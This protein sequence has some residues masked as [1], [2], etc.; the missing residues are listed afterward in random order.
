[1]NPSN[2]G[3]PKRAPT[4]EEG[5]TNNGIPQDGGEERN[6]NKEKPR[7][8]LDATNRHAVTNRA[9]RQVLIHQ[10][11]VRFP[12]AGNLMESLESAG[13]I[14]DA[15][16]TISAPEELPSDVVVNATLRNRLE[17]NQSSATVILELDTEERRNRILRK[18]KKR[19]ADTTIPHD[20]RYKYYLTPKPLRIHTR[21]LSYSDEEIK[22]KANMKAKKRKADEITE[23]YKQLSKGA[24]KGKKEPKRKYYGTPKA[25]T[26]K[27]AREEPENAGPANATSTPLPSISEIDSD[28]PID[29]LAKLVHKI[30]G[31]RIDAPSL[32]ERTLDTSKMDMAMTVQVENDLHK[33]ENTPP[34]EN[35]DTTELDREECLKREIELARGIEM[36]R[37]WA[38]N[39]SEDE[40]LRSTMRE[41]PG[42]SDLRNRNKDL[43]DTMRRKSGPAD[44]RNAR[45]NRDQDLRD[46]M[47]PRRRPSSVPPDLRKPREARNTVEATDYLEQSIIERTRLLGTSIE[48]RQEDIKRMQATVAGRVENVVKEYDSNVTSD[49]GDPNEEGEVEPSEDEMMNIRYSESDSSTRAP[50]PGTSGTRETSPPAAPVKNKAK[51]TKEKKKLIS[52]IKFPNNTPVKNSE[53][54]PLSMLT[55]RRIRPPARLNLQTRLEEAPASTV[56]KLDTGRGPIRSRVGCE[57]PPH[58]NDNEPRISPWL[59]W[60]PENTPR[61]NPWLLAST[62]QMMCGTAH[63]NRSFIEGKSTSRNE[64][65][66]TDQG[67]NDKDQEI[68]EPTVNED[69]VTPEEAGD[70]F[71]D[72]KKEKEKR[73]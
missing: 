62:S 19:Y 27:K 14:T 45:L 44:L 43:R 4:D 26:S 69:D 13:F 28:T 58:Q 70:E 33:N 17:N 11:P 5:E 10:V 65:S 31:P 12:V 51:E 22:A 18:A 32:Q 66:M 25:G 24:E 50:K 42:P 20:E 36:F 35:Q 38:H 7:F 47:G 15:L 30:S 60:L 53:D 9:S 55:P 6:N 57:F 72:P 48:E 1:M 59:P 67:Q 61:N 23:K 41:R 56:P 16:V 71:S 39:C 54:V 52:P 29:T 73:N 8:L 63:R 68:E 40:D 34:R 3:D 64:S 37:S 46:Q 49:S 2:L 21:N